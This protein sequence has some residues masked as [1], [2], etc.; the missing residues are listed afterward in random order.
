MEE[1]ECTGVVS[2]ECV[3]AIPAVG[4]LVPESVVMVQWLP[5]LVAV[6]TPAIPAWTRAYTVV[7][8]P[9]FMVNLALELPFTVNPERSTN[10][11]ALKQ[12]A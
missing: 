11:M 4:D 3:D 10:P 5:H 2:A 1:G 6:V 9:Q 12:Q 7:Q 8:E